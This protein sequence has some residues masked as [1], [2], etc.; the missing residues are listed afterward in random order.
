M[1]DQTT[2]NG[3]LLHIREL[4]PVPGE[5]R[6]C[7]VIRTTGESIPLPVVTE[8][9]NLKVGDFF[10]S[11]QY[12]NVSPDTQCFHDNIMV[13]KNPITNNLHQVCYLLVNGTNVED[14]MCPGTNTFVRY[15]PT[16]EE[17][18][19]IVPFLAN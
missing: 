13:M 2:N 11:K 6:K 3:L 10:V 17:R 16:F 14:R 19:K 1:N 5:I 15:E 9:C 12:W 7:V 18:Y 8:A 4:F